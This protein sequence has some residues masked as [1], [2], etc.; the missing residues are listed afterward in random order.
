MDDTTASG[1]DLRPLL[2]HWDKSSYLA[3]GELAD[4]L[5][6]GPRRE[7]F[8]LDEEHQE[9][10]SGSHL[11]LADFW[12]DYTPRPVKAALMAGEFAVH[13]REGDVYSVDEVREWLPQAGGRFV[14][15]PHPPGRRASS[16]PR[17]NERRVADSARTARSDRTG[18]T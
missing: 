13:L 14:E 11:L 10:A 5:A 15:P 3:W 12:T 6:T 4:A 18:H 8:D 2:R 16:S 17:P 7:V 9:I 1:P